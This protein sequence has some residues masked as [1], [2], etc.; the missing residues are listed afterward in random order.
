V[1]DGGDLPA[2]KDEAL[3]RK[4]RRD[5]ALVRAHAHAAA[6][7]WS[8]ARKLYKRSIDMTPQISFQFIKVSLFLFAVASCK[9]A[10]VL[11]QYLRARKIPYVVAP[12]EADAQL[13]YLEKKGLIVAVLSPDSDLL[14]FGCQTLLFDF[15]YT[16]RTVAC[17]SRR[18]GT[19]ES[20]STALASDGDPI[21]LHG[22]SDAQFRA[23]SI[24][25]GCDYISPLHGING[26]A[27]ARRLIMELESAEEVVYTRF[28]IGGRS[29]P[30]VGYWERFQLAEKCY[31]HQRVYCPLSKKLVHL[32]EVGSEWNDE[33][34][35]YVGR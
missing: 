3:K 2:K 26:L 25:R 35:E 27:V 32:T 29:M 16:T 4:L 31:L 9:T 18:Q 14:V 5:K 19:S 28:L 34:D 33:Y 1:F 30:T 13:A 12:Y 21:T 10:E 6:G 23:M 20:D 8:Q 17:I 7:R 15:N 11:P 24:F 22:L